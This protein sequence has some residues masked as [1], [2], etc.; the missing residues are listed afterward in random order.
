MRFTPQALPLHPLYTTLITHWGKYCYFNHSN[1]ISLQKF[2]FNPWYL[3][4]KN[5]NVSFFRAQPKH[6]IALK[7]FVFSRVQFDTF[8]IKSFSFLNKFSRYDSCLKINDKP[9]IIKKIRIR[10]LRGK[11]SWNSNRQT[12]YSRHANNVM[13]PC[14]MKLMTRKTVFLCSCPPSWQSR[15]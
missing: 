12:M 7:C 8:I 2:L 10:F 13:P 1:C 9:V 15:E 3:T 5:Y 4:W 6:V 14:W 11:K